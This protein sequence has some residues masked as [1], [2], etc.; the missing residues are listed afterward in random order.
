[1]GR[2]DGIHWG[3]GE[4]A[5][6]NIWSILT[7]ESPTVLNEPEARWHWAA[8]AA[9]RP[10]GLTV[11]RSSPE[12]RPA[13]RKWDAHAFSRDVFKNLDAHHD[14]T[15]VYPTDVLLLNELN[16]DYE[17][18]EDH[19]DGGAWD[20][21]PKNWPGLYTE[22]SWF[23]G[24]L[25]TACKE[26]AKDRD[27]SPRWWFPAWSPDHGERDFVG[28][29]E[30]VAD[31][32]DG[33]A[34]HAYGMAETITETVL[35][36][37]KQFPG[38]PLLLSEWNP[39]TYSDDI[40]MRVA[41]EAMTR[42]RLRSLCDAIPRLSATYFIYAWEQDK[43]GRYDIKGNDARL[44]LW[45]GRRALPSDNWTSAFEPAPD[46]P[47]PPEPIVPTVDPYE[48]WT[49]EQ[50]AAASGCAIADV[51]LYWP[52]I[53][54]QLALCGI[55]DRS[56]QVAAIATTAVESSMRPIHEYGPSGPS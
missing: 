4:D 21:N 41:E 17:R 28:R 47:P 16:L 38:L 30:P 2:P 55:A 19:H 12:Q 56:V 1:M 51:A 46:P 44:A 13:D 9:R 31:R 8:V 50:I 5:D 14:L 53:V 29:W 26:R 45:D 33:I 24:D 18:G 49:A 43:A 36:Y 22:L 11:W 15:G 32:F 35:W 23:L 10:N 52:K 25:L 27:W 40:P 3:T 7:S 54:A 37:E 20:T 42:S 48:F 6:S 34:F 39:D